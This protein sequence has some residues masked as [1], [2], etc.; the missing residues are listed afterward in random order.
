MQAPD[1]SNIAIGSP[2][3]NTVSA[4]SVLTPASGYPFNGYVN[5]TNTLGGLQVHLHAENIPPNTQKALHIHNLGDVS[6]PT[7]SAL[8]IHYNPDGNPHG[9]PAL[10]PGS[11]TYTYSNQSHAGDFGNV[12][13][14]AN[15]VIDFT[16]V[17]PQVSIYSWNS[18]SSHSL[19]Q[20]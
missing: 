2:V 14:D 7:A 13:S 5:F 6:T 9:C 12:Q 15:G 16:W 4:V 19:M 20:T 1:S 10:A 8:S 3:Y 17:S 11:N 18:L